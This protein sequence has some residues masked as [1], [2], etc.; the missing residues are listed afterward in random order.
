[1]YSEASDDVLMLVKKKLDTMPQATIP[2]TV[3]K[4]TG[5]IKPPPA[6]ASNP[7][8]SPSKGGK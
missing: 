7:K 4:G 1:L 5:G 3:P 6:P 8:P 2:G